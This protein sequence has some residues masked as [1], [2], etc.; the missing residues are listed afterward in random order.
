MTSDINF[1]CALNGVGTTCM[2]TTF[3]NLNTSQLLRECVEE[4]ILSSRIHCLRNKNII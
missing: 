1:T 4:N 3:L 2:S